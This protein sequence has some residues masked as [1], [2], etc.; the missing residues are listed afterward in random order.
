MLLVAGAHSDIRMQCLCLQRG[1]GN[2]TMCKIF[3]YPKRI[4]ISKVQRAYKAV[5]ALNTS[6]M[7]SVYLL[8][9]YGLVGT[10][11]IQCCAV[12]DTSMEIR[13]FQEQPTWRSLTIQ[14]KRP[15]EGLALFELKLKSLAH[16]SSVS[17]AQKICPSSRTAINAPAASQ[18]TVSCQP[19]LSTW[20]RILDFP[21]SLI[22]LLQLRD[23]SADL[24]DI[25][26]YVQIYPSNS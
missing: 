17:V 20:E 3:L 1:S 14:S 25:S 24:S 13:V 11:E 16:S 15:A 4:R 5:R 7:L 21:H 8:E 18:Q 2:W 23:T 26:T 10:Q 9:L 19:N 6:S 22:P 12:Q